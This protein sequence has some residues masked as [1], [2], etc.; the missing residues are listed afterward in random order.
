MTSLLRAADARP[1]IPAPFSR[2]D[3]LPRAADDLRV[4]QPADPT[5]AADPAAHADPAAPAAPAVPAGPTTP[6]AHDARQPRR[7]P[8]DVLPGL[9][10]T[11]AAVAIAWAVN[12]FA[13]TVSPLTCAV[14]LGAVAANLRLLPRKARPGLGFAGK[15]LMRLGIVLLGLKLALGDVVALG[16]QTLLVTVAVVLLTFLGTQWLGRRM[17]LPGD[18][19]LLVAT[20]FSIC[21]ASAVAAMNSVT[22]SEEDDVITSVALV[23]LCGTLAIVLLPLLQHPLGLGAVPFG[24]WVGASVHDVGQVVATAQG[25]GP[26]ALDQAVVVKMMR[27]ALLAPLV[28]SV[29]LARRRRGSAA[30]RRAS[31]GAASTA[32]DTAGAARPPLVPLFVL[33]FLAMVA[34][35]STGILDAGQL[36]VSQDAANLLMAAGLFALGTGVDV[37]RLAR[38]GGRAVALGLASWLLIAAVAYAGVR[39]TT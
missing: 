3:G 5:A 31:A 18:Q 36:N 1:E 10:I 2:L 29:A 27:I 6:A 7:S 39:L 30:A 28:A 11:A 34:L 17:G 37:R 21:G 15:R 13:P 38:T 19:P 22:D 35:R 8:A 16:W 9:S 20:G 12:R 24:R 14:L 23:T 26:V 4:P 25:A 32:A 33:G